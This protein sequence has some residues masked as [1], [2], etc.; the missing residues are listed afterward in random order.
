MKN[1]ELKSIIQVLGLEMGKKAENL[2]FGKIGLLEDCDR[3][4]DSIVSLL[5]NFFYK[6]WP[7]L[8]EEKR[9]IRILSPLYIAKKGKEIK[10]FYNHSEYKEFT[11][12]GCEGWKIKY[13]KGLGGLGADEYEYMLNNLKYIEFSLDKKTKSMIELVYSDNTDARKEWLT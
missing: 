9:I 3:D 11:N 5:L 13:N 4:G 7:E 1:E 8:I 2:N 6:F 10:R 12:N